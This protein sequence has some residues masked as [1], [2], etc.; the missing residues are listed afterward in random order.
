MPERKAIQDQAKMMVKQDIIEPAKT[1]WS[2]QIIIIKKPMSKGGGFR[3]VNDLR[4]I[5]KKTKFWSY[6]LPLTTD[7]FRALSGNKYFTALDALS[8]FY[9][10]PVK[11]EDRDITGFIVPGLG[12]FRYKRMPQGAKN[13]PQTYSC[14]M[15]IALGDLK[16]EAA[17]VFMDDIL[18]PGK[19]W[20]AHLSKLRKVFSAL[21]KACLTLKY[22]KCIFAAAVIKFLGKIISRHGIKI[23]F[24]QIEAIAKMLITLDY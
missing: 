24:K 16:Y 4:E 15:D 23:D 8:G 18:V 6:E 20:S 9:Q 14:L 22:E 3:L 7:Y 10:I 21:R 11:V 13:A 19:S 1:P 12:S 17:L 2:S 5:N